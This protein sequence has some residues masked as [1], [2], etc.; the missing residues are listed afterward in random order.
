M[1]IKADFVK[2]LGE[3]KVV[4]GEEYYSFPSFERVRKVRP[5][6]LKRKIR[7]TL[8]KATAIIEVAKLTENL[9]PVKRIK[10]R[11]EEFAEFVTKIKGIGKWT[12]ELSVAKVSKSFYV[13]P[14]GDLA[15]KRGFRRMFGIDDEKKN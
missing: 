1:K 12:A 10:R 3:R 4:E 13:G 8:I 6:E 2:K 14:Y 11:P 15:V 7:V 9:S 5:S